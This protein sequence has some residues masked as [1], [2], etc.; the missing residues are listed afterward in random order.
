MLCDEFIFIIRT[1][2]HQI[3]PAS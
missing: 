2:L 1:Q 3:G